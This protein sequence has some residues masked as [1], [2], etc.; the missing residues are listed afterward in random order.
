M[1]P[2][3]QHRTAKVRRHGPAGAALFAIALGCAG[4]PVTPPAAPARQAAPAGASE[5]SGTP[6]ALAPDEARTV[7][8]LQAHLGFLADDLLGGRMAGTPQ[9]EIAARYVAA[10]LAGMGLR[11]IAGGS[12]LL[13]VPL[14]AS[15]LDRES[16]LLEVV[17]GGQRQRLEWGEHFV[18]TADPSHEHSEVEAEVVFVGHGVVAPR[19]RWDDYAGL[20]VR[21]KVV[22]LARGTPASLPP[23]ERAYHSTRQV[24]EAAAR[25]AVGILTFR[26]A[27]DPGPSWQRVVASSG[28]RP[29]LDWL[30]EAGKPSESFPEIRGG[31]RLGEAG[32]AA[33]LAAAG[34]EA[35]ALEEALATG[36]AGGFPLGVGVR[37]AS[38]SR[39]RRLESSN[40]AAVLPGSDPRRRN[41]V[42]VLSAHLDHIGEGGTADGDA[43]HNGY[44]DNAMGTALLLEMARAFATA[45][46]AP[47]RTLV[48]L[49]VTAE[50]SGLLGS[51]HFASRPP[52]GLGRI[53]ANVNLDMPLFLHPV[54]DLVAFGAEHSTLEG[55]VARAAA[56]AGF[57][58]SP[59]PMPAEVIFVRS[60]QYSF[61]RQGIPA[62]YLMPGVGSRDPAVDGAAISRQ[63]FTD[64]Y[65]L[66]G[67]DASLP[68]DWP[69]AVRFLRANVLLAR[70][71]ADAPE[72]PAWKRGDFF[73]EVFGK[74]Q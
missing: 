65:H 26:R 69:S 72:A 30:D 5:P 58:L 41:E 4:A 6:A 45:P 68:V 64:H 28:R 14:Q 7:A 20:D 32:V 73:G 33:V 22:L 47:R 70:A 31:A 43:V 54:S 17:A 74:R 13:P 44:Y 27:S 46:R 16:A 67:D 49:A 62:V 35:G 15:E 3:A 37:L 60:D 48:F 12:Y 9:Y 55:A 1:R 29:Q 50:E 34:R 36:K 53:V 40:V 59:D 11:P 38:R 10:E 18:M 25:G 2:E 51:D 63:F 42:V 23:P 61:V 8:L 19:H 57:V 71:I 39:H 24:A 56:E 66:P 21:G 52:A